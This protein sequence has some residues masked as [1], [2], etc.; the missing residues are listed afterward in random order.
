MSDTRVAE[1]TK[2]G[3]N[4]SIQDVGKLK[5]LWSYYTI[6]AAYASKNDTLYVTDKRWSAAT[7][8]HINKFRNEMQAES[9]ES[10]DQ[11][12][13]EARVHAY[14]ASVRK[15]QTRKNKKDNETFE[16][17][18]EERGTV[19]EIEQAAQRAT[20]SK[21]HVRKIKVPIDVPVMF[22]MGDEEDDD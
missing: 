8:R 9:E 15:K 3:K 7:T 17:I 5:I 13:L 11:F 2:S 21:Q 14:I 10:L 1:T 4:T 12:D 6:V 20:T 16:D 22:V 18:F 19:E